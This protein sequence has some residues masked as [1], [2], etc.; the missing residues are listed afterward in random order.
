MESF[1]RFDLTREAQDDGGY[2][3]TNE[4]D[5]YSRASKKARYDLATSQKKDK[6]K[7]AKGD[8][9]VLRTE[10]S[11]EEM[12]KARVSTIALTGTSSSSIHISYSILEPLVL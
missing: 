2:D 12:R 5:E 3:S 6:R 4:E 9:D 7:H 11:Q 1:Q 8:K 10:S